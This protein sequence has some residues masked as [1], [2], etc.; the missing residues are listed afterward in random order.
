MACIFCQIVRGNSEAAIFWENDDFMAVLDL[1]P[2]VY[3]QALLISKQHYDS[4]LSDMSDNTYEKF[5]SAARQVSNILKAGLPVYRVAMVLEGM[6]INHA[7]IKLYP[8]H[9]LEK[10]FHEMWAQDRVFFEKYTGY[11]TTQLGPETD[12][13]KLKELSAKLSDI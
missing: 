7:H 3:G 4:D 10:A 5:C 9:G 12:I 6:G 2:N 1:F 13:I 11:I 8:L